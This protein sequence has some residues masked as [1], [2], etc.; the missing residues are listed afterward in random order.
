M[1]LVHL[2]GYV[3]CLAGRNNYWSPWG[4]GLE[5]VTINYVGVTIT[6]GANTVLL[7]PKELS[8]QSGQE[9][10]WS[11]VAGYNS[12]SPELVLTRFFDDP[13]TVSADQE[14]RL[15]YTQDLFNGPEFDNGGKV[16][17]DVYVQF[18]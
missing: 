8:I 9:T 3:S 2:Y 4:C 12:Q 13:I 14:L 18:E 16:C 17:C 10:G 5:S 1:K 15:W 11:F 7:P 6:T